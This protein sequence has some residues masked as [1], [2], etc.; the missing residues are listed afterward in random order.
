MK[1]LVAR[2][3][4]PVERLAFEELPTPVPG[5]DEVLVRTQAAAVN[6]VDVVLVT[7]RMREVLPVRHPFVPGVDVSG[8]VAAVGSSVTRLDVGDPVLAWLGLASGSLAE[9]VLVREDLAAVRP[10]GLDAARAAALATGGLTAS[11]LVAAAAIEPWQQVLVWGAAGGVGSFVVQ[12]AKRAGAEV[13]ATG[14]PED[15]EYLR[16]LGADRVIDYTTGDVVRETRRPVPGGVDAVID[17]AHV[18]P[19][20]LEAAAAVR[21]GG[22]VVYVLGGPPPA[23]DRGV[24]A[25]YA[26]AADA[27]EGRLREL[28][29]QAADGGV[30]VELS[31]VYAFADA[32]RA[33]ADFA[34]GHVRGKLAIT[35]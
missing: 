24:T 11:A 29:E 31:G 2:A 28:A 13:V 14:R 18:G 19:D 9:W 34:T 23:L 20:L 10:A 12:L 26:G 1:A 30:R 21:D 27:P 22:R 25:V 7:G 5:P 4:G 32:K 16:G 35:F 3:Y 15:V 8:V 17:V 6:A 33:L